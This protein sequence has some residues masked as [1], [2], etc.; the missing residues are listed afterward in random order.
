MVCPCRK[1]NKRKTKRKSRRRR[2]SKKK[3]YPS[4]DFFSFAGETEEDKKKR[5][6]FQNKLKTLL[7]KRVLIS[8]VFKESAEPPISFFYCKWTDSFMAFTTFEV[9]AHMHDLLIK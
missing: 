8:S 7:N 6:D 5:K 3:K 9:Y 1:S 4:R 2:L